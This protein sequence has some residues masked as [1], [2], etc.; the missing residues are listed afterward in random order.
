VS[1]IQ[2][3]PPLAPIRL[4]L[5]EEEGPET[6][7]VSKLLENVE[8]LD[9]EVARAGG[10]DDALE[11]LRH[12]DHHAVLL[13][14]ALPDAL[15]MLPRFKAAADGVPII[16][17]TDCDDAE[18]TLNAL[19]LGA[20]DQI[21]KDRPNPYLVARVIQ[22]AVEQHCTLRELERSREREHYLANHD[23]LT[24]LPN[25]FHFHELLRR[26]MANASR[27][28][29]SVA[30]LFLDLDRFKNINDSLGHPAGDELLKLT[31]QRL[32]E[33]TRRSDI[34]V[35]LGG[36]EFAV[37]LQNLKR[38][39]APAIVAEKILNALAKP[40]PLAER[41]CWVT[42][43]IGIAVFPRD[44]IDIDALIR[45]ADIALYEAKSHG[46]NAYHFHAEQMNQLAAERLGLQNS[47][48]EAIEQEQFVLHF[49]PQVDIST[50]DL[51]GAEAL[52]RWQH[53]DRGLL[54]PEAFLHAAE[55]GGMIDAIGGWM[56]RSA[57]RHAAQWHGSRPEKVRVSVN[58]S[59]SQLGQKG[60]VDD[61]VR[62]LG[63]NGLDAS[64]LELEI[65]ERSVHSSGGVTRAT[66]LVLRR[67]GVRVSVDDFGTVSTSLA[68]LKGVPLD[69]FKIHHEFI[70]DIPNDP[71]NATITR[72]LIRMARG[73]GLVTA[74][75]GIETRE[76]MR[77]LFTHGCH[78]LQGAL[79]GEPVG[80]DEFAEQ[81]GSK[82]P[83]WAVDLSDLR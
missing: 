15:E 72:A 76:Q 45:N 49:Q 65:T 44:G 73:L 69:G 78:R 19:R 54:A 26:S 10:L 57:C 24:G 42:A 23:S 33:V 7:S 53:P 47:L 38:D 71:T 34:V 82:N 11:R 29:K 51:L 14:L 35:R 31:A 30:V 18:F 46:S 12:G 56:L 77:F 70:K 74:A 25:R 68:A 48:H 66:L 39:H 64:Q 22:R 4:L 17:M 67:L 27:S 9:L 79:L 32:R 2:D 61:V 43:S 16:V 59:G 3:A 75:E 62:V 1:H 28:G 60:F 81:L 83:P 80:A 8:P 5:V 21:A 63:E 6:Q 50:G 37:M 58:V 13:D 41:G 36:D 55:D 52:L 40:F 20:H